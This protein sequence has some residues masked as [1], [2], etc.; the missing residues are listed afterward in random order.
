VEDVTLPG[1]LAA[2]V[3]DEIEA[4]LDSTPAAWGVPLEY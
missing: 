1:R 4:A 2:A 3:E